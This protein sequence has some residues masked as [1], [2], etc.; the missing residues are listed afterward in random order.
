MKSFLSTVFV[1]LICLTAQAQVPS[2]FTRFSC[3][4]II[5]D[6]FTSSFKDR[7]KEDLDVHLQN[8]TL[9]KRDAKEFA[10][11][12]NYYNHNLL[13]SGS[14]L[15]GDQIS[16]YAENI[17]DRLLKDNEE[18]REEVRVYTIK[19]NHVNAYSTSNGII[20]LTLG[21]MAK[22]ESEA[23]LAFVLSHELGHIKA[24]HVFQSFTD[25]KLIW[26]NSGGYRKM[27]WEERTLT[28]FKH[29]RDAE[30]EAD[31]T[32][33][34]IYLKAGYR[35]EE[36][37]NGFDVLLMGYLPIEQRQYDFSL[38]ESDSFRIPDNF[39]IEAVDEIMDNEG[40]DDTEHTH[41]NVKKRK[42][43]VNKVIEQGV[44]DMERKDFWIYTKEEFLLIR[45][46]TRFEMINSFLRNANYVSALY[47]I[48]VLKEQYPDHVFLKKAELMCWAGMQIFINNRQKREYSTGYRK[49]EGELQA[50]YYFASKMSKKGMNALATRFI[51]EQSS[52]MVQDEFVLALKEQCINELPRGGYKKNFFRKTYPTPLPEGRTKR[53]AKKYDF[54]KI[55]FIDLFTDSTFS[56]LY[57]EAFNSALHNDDYDDYDFDTEEEDDVVADRNVRGVYS[58]Y[59]L[60]GVDKLL[61]FSP[62]FFRIDLRKDQDQMFLTS[63]AQQNDLEERTSKLSQLAGLE[64]VTINDQKSDNYDTESFNDYMILNDWL[65]EESQYEGRNFYSFTSPNL[66]HIREKYQTDFLGVNYV[67]HFTDTKEFSPLTAIV[68]ALYIFPFPYYLYWQLKPDHQLDYTFAV[69]D[70]KGGDMEFL[71]SK[72]FSS[73]YRKD[74]I[75]AHLFNSFNQLSR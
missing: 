53:K 71:D 50:L 63:D 30:Y 7:Y 32:G 34:E 10:V 58:Y 55:A 61:F 64:L 18:F 5:P 28:S 19:S 33:L 49:Q 59:G 57:S 62:R 46:M 39:F 72:S 47:H 13:Q 45:D 12:T 24:K 74:V 54:A 8:T 75:N 21:L 9:K 3:E 41:P 35:I 27:N 29:S 66:V 44:E 40:V 15:Y 37:E 23:Q 51:W 73:K 22:V 67:W 48:Q 36:I 11:L 16:T 68:S 26:S 56:A 2:N 60:S 4:G 20:F 42:E 38:L 17:L 31:E 43:A 25:H 70:L 14:V 1:F 6:D 52:D 69:F 65:R